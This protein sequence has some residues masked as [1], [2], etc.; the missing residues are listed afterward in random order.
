[1]RVVGLKHYEGQAAFDRGLLRDGGK[2]IIRM[3]GAQPTLNAGEHSWS[4]R[5]YCGQSL[6][7]HLPSFASEILRVS[8]VTTE[9]GATVV[10]INQKL[11][12]TTSEKILEVSVKIESPVTEAPQGLRL[13]DVSKDCAGVYAIINTQNMKAY[14]G[15]T[16]NLQKR[17]GE[18]LQALTKG[19]HFKKVLQG[20]WNRNP[21]NFAFTIIDESPNNLEQQEKY[22]IF[23]YGTK[24]R[25]N[26]Y[27]AGVGFSPGFHEKAATSLT[28]GA[29]LSP[30]Y[31]PAATQKNQKSTFVSNDF[32]PLPNH[33]SANSI[34]SYLENLGFSVKNHR[35]K[36]GGIWAFH[37]QSEFKKMAKHLE[38][39]GIKV[40]YYPEGR[41]RHREKHFGIDPAKKLPDT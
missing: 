28:K 19:V 25:F 12:R 16:T 21:E 38:K 11:N 32:P 20:E 41:K 4:R 14:I 3:V 24:Q 23:L 40:K 31:I 15:Q 34:C 8:N 33:C 1:M 5:V 13:V 7:G 29:E 22:R 37:S 35:P 36:G 27:N 30:S 39:G 18:H 2:L 26:G 17:K 6:I 9:C 10:N